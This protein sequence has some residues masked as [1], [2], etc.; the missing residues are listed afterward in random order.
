MLGESS[1]AHRLSQDYLLVLPLVD[2]LEPV[3]P[4][5][6]EGELELLAP[7]VEE[8]VV[9]PVVPVAPEVEPDG[10][11]ELLEPGVAEELLVPDVPAAS[12]PEVPA[13]VPP[14]VPVVPVAPL[15]AVEPPPLV[16]AAPWSDPERLQLVNATLSRAASNTI[17]E[18][19]AIAFITDPFK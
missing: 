5:V 9:P 11:V 17:F 14:V 7:G 13:D 6:P 12:E 8:P 15:V 2:S 1:T 4:V 3:V 16:P 18:V 19:C 10:V